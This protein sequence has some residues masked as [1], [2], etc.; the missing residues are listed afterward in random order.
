[1][2]SSKI[3]QYLEALLPKRNE[4]VEEIEHYAKENNVPIM[5]LVGIETMLQILRISQPKQILEIGTAIGYS[6]IRMAQALP[7]TK[8]VSLERDAE[9]YEKAVENI[10]RT[11]TSSQIEVIFGD[12]LEVADEIKKHGEFDCIFIDAAK[13][14]YRHFFDIYEKCLSKDGLIVTDNVLFKGLV[15]E[16]EIENKRIR[17]LVTKIKSYN[18]WLLAHPDYQTTILPVGDGV[19]LS[20]RRG[21][22]E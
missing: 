16:E 18:E 19:A 2:L 11:G 14:Q 12:A 13:G 9:R 7:G 10:E 8:I 22:K 6:A 5:E 4:I 15:A 20:K 17:N 21:V 3:T 1:M